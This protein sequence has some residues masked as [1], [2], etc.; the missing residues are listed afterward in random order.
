M[1]VQ[2]RGKSVARALVQLERDSRII[3]PSLRAELDMQVTSAFG[4]AQSKI[5]VE[6]GALLASGRCGSSVRDGGDTYVGYM[7]WG[8][9]SVPHE[10]DYAIFVAA[11][12]GEFDWLRDSWAYDEAMEETIGR[13]MRRHLR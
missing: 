6:S 4:D 13:H 1:I 9:E 7:A 10:V 5:P 12:G 11:A 3:T 2:D 8:G